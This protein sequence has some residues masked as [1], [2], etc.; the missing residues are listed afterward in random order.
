MTSKEVVKRAVHFRNPPYI[1]LLYYKSFEKA[2]LLSIPIEKHYAGADG[3]TSEWGFKWEDFEFEFAFGQTKSPAIQNWNDLEAYIP[4]DHLDLSRFDVAKEMMEKYPDR[5]Y[6]ADLSL[7]G[8]TIMTFVRGFENLL[9]DLYLEPEKVEQLADIVFG[10]EEELIRLAAGHGFDAVQFA[11][12]WGSQQS[13]LISPEMFRKI[14][15]PRY[16]K[17][18]AL[19]HKLGLDVYL[20]SCGYILDIIPDLIEIGL[21]ILNPGQPSLNGIEKLGMQFGGKICF[22]CPVN[23]QTTGVSGTPA[24]INQEV[25]A[26]VQHL[27][28]PE[29]GFIGLVTERTYQL[30]ASQENQKAIIAAFEA[31]CGKN[32]PIDSCGACR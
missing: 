14:F 19:A 6:I 18:Y 1:P 15:K 7:S 31:Y 8:F 25:Q 17:Q 3:R 2:D 32:N 10:F 27:S 13:L 26:Y 20:H 28:R 21:D 9:E 4:P 5:Y 24:E 16:Q 29:G 22:A 12:D 11:D 23:Y 30:G